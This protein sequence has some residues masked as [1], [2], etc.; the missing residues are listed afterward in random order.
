[1]SKVLFVEAQL[2]VRLEATRASLLLALGR[3]FTS[4]DC[5][6]RDSV[7]QKNAAEAS[8]R[9]PSSIER[10]IFAHD[11]VTTSRRQRFSTLSNWSREGIRGRSHETNADL[12]V[13]LY[14]LGAS[15]Y[16][17]LDR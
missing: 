13:R 6:E 7:R 1:M 17:I 4:G 5:E 15:D 11:T 14:D 10:C 8:P 12:K 3:V 2:Q 16:S 9:R